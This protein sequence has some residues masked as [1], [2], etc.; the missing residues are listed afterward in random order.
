M[1]D[2]SRGKIPAEKFHLDVRLKSA[3][4]QR[5]IAVE[6]CLLQDIQQ[7]FL[8]DPPLSAEELRQQYED[9]QHDLAAMQFPE[10]RIGITH[11]ASGSVLFAKIGD[12]PVSFGD[13]PFHFELLR[14]A[15]GYALRLATDTPFM[16]DIYDIL[17]PASQG[18]TSGWERVDTAAGPPRGP[19]NNNDV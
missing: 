19:E 12:V 14:S 18:G 3:E 8:I 4:D 9:I 1:S 16:E 13:K 10:K 7:N 15:G 2:I 6:R 17:Y 5:V 11:D